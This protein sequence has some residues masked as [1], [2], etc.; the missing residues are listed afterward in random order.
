VTPPEA[1]PPD[2]TPP[3][4]AAPEDRR[5]S[6][7]ALLVRRGALRLLAALDLYAL[8]EVT[9]RSGRR[10]DLAAVARTGEIW[11]VEIKSSRADLLADRKWP[12][13]RAFC[14]RLFFATLP[15]VDEALFPADAGLIVAD[16]YGGAIL[17]DAPAHPL[18]AATRKALLTRMAR[19]GA[20]RLSALA[21]PG[22]TLP[23]EL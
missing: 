20:A 7:R 18:P 15:D 1:E 14:D 16:G 17:R 19:L 4:P 21:D 2:W 23:E 6:A 13:Y 22:F 12:D 9:L 10:A 11:I 5:Q 8:P 3:G